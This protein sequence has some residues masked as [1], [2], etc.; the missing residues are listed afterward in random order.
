MK[1]YYEDNDATIYQG[2]CLQVMGGMADNSI[3]TIIT[4]PPYGLSFMGKNWDYGIPGVPYWRETLRVA[5]PGAMLLAFG[6]TRTFHRLTCAIEDTGWE[7][8]DCIVYFH[9][10]SLQEAAFMDSLDEEQLTAYLELH[11]PN[12]QIAWVYGSG[13]PKSLDISKAIDKVKGAEREVVG[14]YIVPADSDAGN[15]GR[16]LTGRSGSAKVNT[17]SDRNGPSQNGHPITAPSTPLAQTFAGYGSAIKPAW[18]PIIVAMKPLD[19]T[20]AQNA[21]RWGVAGLNIDGATVETE[22]TLTR[23]GLNPLKSIHRSNYLQGYRPNDYYESDQER[24]VWGSTKGRYPANLIHDGSPEVMAEFDKAGVRKSG[25]GNGLRKATGRKDWGMGARHDRLTTGEVSP[26]E[27]SA[28]RFFYCAKSSPSERGEGNTHP[29]VKPLKLL[30]YL[31]RLTRT[32]YGGIILDPF[33]G[34]GTTLLAARAEGRKAIGID[35]EVEYCEIAKA[36][37]TGERTVSLVKSGKAERK[38]FVRQMSLFGEA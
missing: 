22:D 38:E 12:N 18:E 17:Y 32:P 15:A 14:R 29:T 3:D 7:I 21:E 36:R 19:G 2:D 8:R 25:G 16:V 33:M 6:G 28:A 24:A 37:L 5:K 20:Y 10:A 27:G 4:D 26:S 34:S 31:A 1:P 35:L 11:Y 30:R 13:F 9:D 23:E